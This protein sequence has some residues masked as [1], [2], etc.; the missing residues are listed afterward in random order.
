MNK[1]NEDQIKKGA[2]YN[3]ILDDEKYYGKC[4]REPSLDS[5]AG[6]YKVGV[7]CHKDSEKKGYFYDFTIPLLKIR[8]IEEIKEVV[9]FEEK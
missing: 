2:W 9:E 1:N 3:F 5:I 6:V 4:V 7:S 8:N